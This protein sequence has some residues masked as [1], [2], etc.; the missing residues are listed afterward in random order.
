MRHV[1]PLRLLSAIPLLALLLSGRPAAAAELAGVSMAE[2]SKVGDATLRLNGMALRSKAIFKVYVGGL[3]LPEE[4]SSWQQVLAEDTARQMVMH[5][6]RSVDKE[7]ICDGWNDSLAA[8]T[9]NASAE[10]KQDFATLCG[11]MTDAR[12]GDRFVFTYVPGKGTTV[13]VGESA[14]GTI[15]GKPF[16]D[17]LFASWIGAKP[18]PGEAFREDLMGG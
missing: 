2:T 15:A 3:Y 10:L 4:R 14:K 9:P 11:W 18:G 1:Q 7:A 17:A 12:T 5:W 16:A 8:N 6:V 13:K